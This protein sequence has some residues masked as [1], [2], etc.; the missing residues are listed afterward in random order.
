MATKEFSAELTA[1]A[2]KMDEWR[3]GREKRTRIP[4]E[5]WDETIH[6][7]KRAGLWATAKATRIHYP[8]LKERVG[9]AKVQ[10]PVRLAGRAA[11]TGGAGGR[12]GCGRAN[13]T[14]V[15]SRASFVELPR[16]AMSAGMKTVVEFEGKGGDRMRIEVSG[17]VDLAGLARAF[18][19][20]DAR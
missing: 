15:A 14:G 5:L 1:L 4:E 2:A 6:L 19:V 17:G 7:A 3:R 8:D 18:Y 12:A 16:A 9:V 11:M 10:G 13:G 20:R